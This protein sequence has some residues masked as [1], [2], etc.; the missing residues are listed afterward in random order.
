MV[1]VS[2]RDL[3]YKCQKSDL[4]Q[5]GLDYVRLSLEFFGRRAFQPDHDP[6]VPGATVCDFP[7]ANDV[8]LHALFGRECSFPIRTDCMTRCLKHDFLQNGLDYVRLSLEFF[9]RR[10]FQPDLDPDDPG[11]NGAILQNPKN[12]DF[13]SEFS[14][15]LWDVLA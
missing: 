13:A 11:A 3:P 12:P 5:N 8:D 1:T 4:L 10:T 2:F 9:G 14:H 7:I 6:D 15:L